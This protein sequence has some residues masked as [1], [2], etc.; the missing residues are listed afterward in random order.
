MNENTLLGIASFKEPY[1]EPNSSDP[2]ISSTPLLGCPSRR[3]IHGPHLIQSDLYPNHMDVHQVYH[4]HQTINSSV[5]VH[6]V[7]T[8][9]SSVSFPFN[10]PK[11]SKPQINSLTRIDEQLKD[12]RMNICLKNVFHA[13]PACFFLSN[14][15]PIV[16]TSTKRFTIS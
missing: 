3:F 15:I 13:M 11:L 16:Y 2:L 1:H 9:A 6:L 12:V 8:V 5:F 4:P 10:R 14:Q 7:R